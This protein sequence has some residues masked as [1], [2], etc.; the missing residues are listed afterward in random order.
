MR[1]PLVFFGCLLSLVVLASARADA[2]TEFCPAH[3]GTV[4]L[5]S[6]VPLDESNGLATIFA[7]AVNGAAPREVY[8]SV[9]VDTDKGWF[10]FPFTRAHLTRRIYHFS[11]GLRR[12]TF[13]TA[14]SEPL[15]VGF[16]MPVRIVSAYV[17]AAH[18]TDDPTFNWD[19]KGDV[20]CGPPAGL[21]APPPP[22]P[23]KGA[24]HAK[25]DDPRSDLNG[26][27]AAGAPVASATSIG[28]PGDLSCKEPF[29]QA[30]VTHEMPVDYPS[31]DA[32]SRRPG[33]AFV[34]VAI[35]GAGNLLD[36][37]LSVETDSRPMNDAALRAARLSTYKG[38]T[39][40]CKPA[41]GV[42]IFRVEFDPR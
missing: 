40:F 23:P 19:A 12:W 37:W 35:D 24:V 29:T 21:E 17:N 5:Q 8:G 33:T 31:Q 22:P 30:T 9:I 14:E 16:P 10:T 38:G 11:Q 20:V 39:A 26:E 32:D 6:I 34:D 25:L 4:G 36:A 27:P 42:Y 1:V 18:A 7:Y 3:I 13:P 2:V 28:P 41:N 15:Y